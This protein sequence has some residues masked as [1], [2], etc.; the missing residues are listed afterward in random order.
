[1]NGTINSNPQNP[2]TTEGIPASNWIAGR[3]ILL[4]EAGANSV[5]NIAQQ[6]PIGTPRS[7]A[8]SVT[9]TEP[10][11]I[12]NIPNSPCPGDQ[13]IPNI[14]LINPTSAM[15]GKP[16]TMI[17]I[18]IS[19][20]ADIDENASAKNIYFDRFSRNFFKTVTVPLLFNHQMFRV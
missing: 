3:K 20:S 7:A 2:Y 16:L 19:A 4:S 5:K 18:V 13:D 8:P 17:K 11:I 1:M 12:G 15:I 10:I 9:V 6:I 14:K